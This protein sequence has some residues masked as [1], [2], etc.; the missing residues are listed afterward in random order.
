MSHYN[1]IWASIV[2]FCQTFATANAPLTVVNLDAHADL[3]SLPTSDIIGPKNY[4]LD[5]NEGTQVASVMLVVSTLDD[6][7]L[8]RLDGL[9][10]KLYQQLTPGKTIPFINADTGATMGVLKI[11]DGTSVSPVAR[12]NSRPVKFVGIDLVVALPGL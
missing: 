8:F 3:T 12:T 11:M 7:N 1:D 10:G 4:M 6:E 5:Y 2:K 9:M